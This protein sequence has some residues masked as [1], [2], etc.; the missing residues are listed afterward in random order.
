MLAELFENYFFENFEYK[1]WSKEYNNFIAIVYKEKNFC[2]LNIVKNNKILRIEFKDDF[3]QKYIINKDHNL[4]IK[5]LVDSIFCD[6][7]IKGK[8][9]E[10]YL[11]IIEGYF[12]LYNTFQYTLIH[13]PKLV[14][15]ML[16][17]IK[18][19]SELSVSYK[20]SPL[21]IYMHEINVCDNKILT[22]I[23]TQF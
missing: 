1:F 3:L 14:K 23:S 9:I 8:Y 12:I 22:S 5:A 16:K 11:E 18:V 20:N 10:T 17:L 2:V 15:D 6:I 7:R 19:Y 4:C 21:Q 13:N